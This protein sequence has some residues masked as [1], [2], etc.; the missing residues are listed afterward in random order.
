MTSPTS[1]EKIVW[2]LAT[3]METVEV[4]RRLMKEALV[5][6]IEAV[7]PESARAT[8]CCGARVEAAAL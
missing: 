7:Q 1:F 4:G 5:E 6:N 2:L 3:E 8:S